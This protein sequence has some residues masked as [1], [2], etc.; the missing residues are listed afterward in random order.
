M[1]HDGMMDDGCVPKLLI[2]KNTILVAEFLSW[3]VVEFEVPWM[4]R[5]EIV[6]SNLQINGI[7]NMKERLVVRFQIEQHQH[8]QNI[9]LKMTRPSQDDV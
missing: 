9:T 1:I 3:I 2:A 6:N 4:M 7:S 5:V 8:H